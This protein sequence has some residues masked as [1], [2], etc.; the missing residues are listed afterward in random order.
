MIAPIRPAKITAKVTTLMST[1]P[2]PDGLRDGRAEGER[3]DEVE[4]G[5]PDDRFA[6]R[7][8]P[9]RHD[10]RDRVGG[11]VEPVDVVEKQRDENQREDGEKI[12]VHPVTR[13]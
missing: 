10:R 9:R 1:S 3:G 8:D 11:V 12:G 2:L 6:R 13:A 7:E 4:K 5:G